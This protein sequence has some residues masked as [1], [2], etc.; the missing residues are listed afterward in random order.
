MNDSPRARTTWRQRVVLAGATLILAIVVRSRFFLGDPRVRVWDAVSLERL[1]TSLAALGVIEALQFLTC[2]VFGAWVVA[3]DRRRWPEELHRAARMRRG[4]TAAVSAVGLVVVAFALA[5]WR[6]PTV[7]ELVLPLTGTLLGAYTAWW[8]AGGRRARRW[9]GV[10]AVALVIAFTVGG[11]WIA[12]RAIE[13]RP[14]VPP[15]RRVTSAEKRVVMKK[16]ADSEQGDAGDRKVVL[17]NDDVNILLS[18][19][20]ALSKD[21]AR[22][23]GR[24]GSANDGI[25]QLTIPLGRSEAASRF[26]N[27]ETA[28]HGYIRRGKVVFRIQSLRIGS[29][30]VPKFLL[31]AVSF[32]IRDFAQRDPQVRQIVARTEML[33]I[34]DGQVTLAGNW[35]GMRKEITGRVIAEMGARSELAKETRIYVRRLLEHWTPPSGSHDGDEVFLWLTRQAFQ[36]AGERIA[37]GHDPVEENS[38][39]ILALGMLVGHSKL[40]RLIGDVMTPELRKLHQ[41]K[42]PKPT[43]Y[44]RSDWP[45]HFWLSAAIAVLSNERI[46]HAVGVLKEEL[47]AGEGGSGFS[48]PD[49]AADMAG[50]RL[51]TLAIGNPSTAKRVQQGLAKIKSLDAVLPPIRDLPEGL[52]DREFIRRFGSVEDERYRQMVRQIEQR[53]NQCRLLKE[54]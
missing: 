33:V 20:S 28:L 25:L 19:G 30:D 21:G 15:R 14:L 9:L 29:I 26:L 50:T 13:P 23:V 16:L 18:M 22:V 39:A 8:W 11:Y 1:V 40:E 41:A 52:S 5:R 49:L 43:M 53:L 45:R 24:V 37:K 42:R 51:A 6:I 12:T 7:L 2:G 17:T 4:A 10:Q 35:R 46:G 31:G 32:L 38:A 34:Q 54:R 47:D 36:L 44:G 27:A 3:Y 48:F